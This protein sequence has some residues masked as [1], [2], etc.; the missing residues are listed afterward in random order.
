MITEKELSECDREQLHLLGNIQDGAG[1]VLFFS[2]PS[3]EILAADLK[4]RAVPWIRENSSG[5]PTTTTTTTTTTTAAAVEEPAAAEVG[6]TPSGSGSGGT[7]VCRKRPFSSNTNNNNNNDEILSAKSEEEK[8][9]QALANI[10]VGNLNQAEQ[11]LLLQLLEKLENF[12]Q[13]L[14]AKS[15]NED[16]DGIVAHADGML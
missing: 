9:M 1:N 2:Y 4:V 5:D 12:H 3:R 6:Y 8:D 15:K 10:A 13:V 16:F 11:L 14:L 7:P